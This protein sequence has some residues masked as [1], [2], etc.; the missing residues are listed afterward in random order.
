MKK[1]SRFNSLCT[2]SKKVHALFSASACRPAKTRRPEAAAANQ[3]TPKHERP[4]DW[5]GSINFLNTEEFQ[6]AISEHKC[7]LE[8]CMKAYRW[9]FRSSVISVLDR[10]LENEEARKYAMST[11]AYSALVNVGL[12]LIGGDIQSMAKEVVK[13]QKEYKYT[14]EFSWVSKRGIDMA[15]SELTRTARWFYV[16]GR[17]VPGACRIRFVMLILHMYNYTAHFSAV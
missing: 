5:G 6:K 17:G 15:M 11:P 3:P 10:V 2:P 13:V 14:G 16:K 8:V 1:Y 12:E 9:P 7:P 4:E